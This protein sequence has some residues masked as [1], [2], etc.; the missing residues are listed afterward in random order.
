MDLSVVASELNAVYLETELL[1]KLLTD[2]LNDQKT[3]TQKQLFS[4]LFNFKKFSENIKN[5]I[6]LNKTIKQSKKNAKE[7]LQF[8]KAQKKFYYVLFA[9]TTTSSAA[10]LFTNNDSQIIS[11]AYEARLERVR[12]AVSMQRLA[13]SIGAPQ[14][15]DVIE[16]YIEN[17]LTNVV[18]P[19]DSISN[20]VFNNFTIPMQVPIEFQSGYLPI[21]NEETEDELSF[22]DMSDEDKLKLAEMMF[23]LDPSDTPDFYE[24][25]EGSEVS[26]LEFQAGMFGPVIP[27]E[28]TDTAEILMQD[29]STFTQSLRGAIPDAKETISG[30]KTLVDKF[31]KLMIPENE[32][33][34]KNLLTSALGQAGSSFGSTLG[35]NSLVSDTFSAMSIV[36]LTISAI[37]YANHVTK[38]NFCVVMGALMAACWFNKDRIGTFIGYVVKIHARSTSVEF[39]GNFDFND[40]V[41]MSVIFLAPFILVTKSVSQLP[42]AIW[43]LVEKFDK[44]SANYQSILE[45]VMKIVTELLD[46]MHL[47]DCI[48]S[49]AKRITIKDPETKDLL[50]EL[51]A[52][53][54]EYFDNKLPIC[55]D[56][57]VKVYNFHKKLRAHF[58]TIPA[59]SQTVAIRETLKTELYKLD[60]ILSTFRGANSSG[61]TKRIEP[62]FINVVGAPGNFKTQAAE[63]FMARLQAAE[64]NADEM[65][66][67]KENR[68]RFIYYR[69]PEMQYHDTLRGDEKIMFA[70]DYNQFTTDPTNLDNIYADIM[71]AVGE[72]PYAAHKPDLASKGNTFIQYSYILTT[73]NAAVIEIPS[74]LSR[75]AFYRRMHLPIYMVPK[76]EYCTKETVTNDI[77]LRKLDVE[78]DHL[79]KGPDGLCSTDPGLLHDFYLYEA[80]TGHMREKMSFEQVLAKAIKMRADRVAYFNQKNKEI[81]ILYNSY[82]NHVTFQMDDPWE[83]LEANLKEIERAPE[84]EIEYDSDS[85]EIYQFF[86]VLTRTQDHSRTKRITKRLDELMVTLKTRSVYGLHFETS[87]GE[88]AHRM[89][90]IFG[91]PFL[92]FLLGNE[93]V[94]QFVKEHYDVIGEEYHQ[95]HVNIILPTKFQ[96]LKTKIVDFLDLIYTGAKGIMYMAFKRAAEWYKNNKMVVDIAIGLFAT[97]AATT[98]VYSAATM[99]KGK[100]CYRY[101]P[102]L[103]VIRLFSINEEGGQSEWFDGTHSH[104]TIRIIKDEKELCDIVNKH[105]EG[106]TPDDPNYSRAADDITN[107]NMYTEVLTHQSSNEHTAK[108]GADKRN[109]KAGKRSTKGNK[110][111]RNAHSFA[112]NGGREW[113][114]G[115]VRDINA[116]VISDTIV[117]KSLL[118]FEAQIDGEIDTYYH[119]GLAFVVKD[120][121]AIINNHYLTMLRKKVAIKPSIV[122]NKLRFSKLLDGAEEASYWYTT[123][124]SFLNEKNII[125][126]EKLLLRDQALVKIPIG[127]RRFRDVTKF[128]ATEKDHRNKT[129]FF[130]SLRSIRDQDRFTAV[131]QVK[132]VHSIL[133]NGDDEP[134]SVID[135]YE[136][137]AQT[138][139]GD[140]GSLLFLENKGSATGKL[141]GLHCSGSV[142][143]GIGYSSALIKEN[144]LEALEL[145][146]LE[147]QIVHE[148]DD[149]IF[150]NETFSNGQFED[151]YTSEYKL[152]TPGHTKLI[153]SDLYEAWGSAKTKPAHLRTFEW[154]GERISPWDKALSKVCKG[155]VEI[156]NMLALSCS[157]AYL[158]DMYK[159]SREVHSKLPIPFS[160][161]ILG[162]EDNI[163]FSAISRST[164]PG[165]PYVL[166]KNIMRKG[167]K[168]HWFGDND[169]YDMTTAAVQQLRENCMRIISLA[170]QGI[171]AEHVFVDCLKDE[172]RPIAKVDEGKT[173]QFNIGPFDL[174]V[175]FRMYFGPFIMW[176]LM[177]HSVNGSAIGANPFS[178]DWDVIA[179]F[180]STHGI[181]SIGAGDFSGFDGSQKPEILWAVL[182]MINKW[183]NDSPENQ[184]VRTVLWAEVVNSSHINGSTRYRWGSSMP[185]G[186]A[187]TAIVN[188]IYVQ[189]A[190]RYCYVLA[191]ANDVSALTHFADN[192]H[193]IGLGDDNVFSVHPDKHLIFNELTLAV[194]MKHLGL[195]YTTEMKG[196]ATVP[197]R[198]LNEVTFLKRKFIY[199]TELH[200]YIAPLELDVVL[201]IPYWTKTHDSF[202]IM[203]DNVDSTICELSLHGPSTYNFFVPKIFEEAR[204]V[205][206]TPK[207][208]DYDIS[209]LT[210]LNTEYL[211]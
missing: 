165:F 115:M 3:K 58:M 149:F 171:R 83:I 168:H 167:G 23:A 161:A 137:H 169:E 130:G 107:M 46:M 82:Q 24:D 31:N 16:S 154:N 150:S 12:R 39:Q 66:Q 79:P 42:S 2:R 86:S 188:T 131:V 13:D 192:V 25:D 4:S 55:S 127:A 121:M 44:V 123:I 205:G 77:M 120:R 116:Q 15:E 157:N 163:F 114:M 54:K 69:F 81:S 194:L 56:N 176:Y 160:F 122:R 211:F 187:L 193:V 36:F 10:A 65:R 113:E 151:V 49:W 89:Y 40:I 190:F 174:L 179:R 60:K 67:I 27:E 20:D 143:T 43:T 117:N 101:D 47:S 28:L 51:D 5:I 144:I 94:F 125:V 62:V 132:P 45:F 153:Q 133:V 84:Y 173:R 177:N 26:D 182:T 100:P 201:E 105:N 1:S 134:V 50:V 85:L 87:M 22:F 198:R 206:Y 17:H 208:N 72:L 159:V 196:V 68:N 9:P 129:E 185:S 162:I 141:F 183:F 112:D 41:K 93:S 197:F 70:D 103:E 152:H 184:L 135:T 29:I 11:N 19:E 111:S 181:Q 102:K 147:D 97:A 32:D 140:C 34:L 21:I 178:M 138:T 209:L 189:T 71:R 146:P 118:T 108:F 139:K 8:I 95:Q 119:L 191:H 207:T 78:G 53:S 33:K 88:F 48:P 136:Y 35:L 204:K 57:G 202:K 109:K 104:R 210:T 6:S 18:L 75:D 98:A 38:Q 92:T 80:T 128:I 76:P 170:K 63:H 64:C 96:A 99:H 145:C 90:A 61:D 52:L 195:I 186:F 166:D 172:R 59:N 74:L 158:L 14:H 73:S 91:P 106:L 142:T 148:N 199:S 126:T 156:D 200:Q 124:G 175:L 37:N 164:S 110:S 30:M 180:L 7:L 155:T 203:C